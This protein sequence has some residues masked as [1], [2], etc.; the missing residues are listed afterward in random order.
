[1]HLLLC[2]AH[3]ILEHEQNIRGAPINYQIIRFVDY[4]VVKLSGYQIIRI[5]YTLLHW[6]FLYGTKMVNK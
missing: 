6:I 3:F 4:S 1:M 2:L 5:L